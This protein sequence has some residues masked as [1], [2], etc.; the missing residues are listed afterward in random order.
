MDGWVGG[1][2]HGRAKTDSVFFH[3]NNLIQLF[4]LF[5]T[6]SFSRMDKKSKSSWLLTR[7]IHKVILNFKI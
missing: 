3:S 6:I 2:I 5:R 4:L 1:W 7:Y